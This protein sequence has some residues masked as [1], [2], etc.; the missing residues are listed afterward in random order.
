MSNKR[1]VF[2][3]LMY[4][5]IVDQKITKCSVTSEN[6]RKQMDALQKE[7][8]Y[9]YDLS[10]NNDASDGNYC[11]L[12]FDDGHKSN[13]EAARLLSEI[14]LKGYFY[15]IKDYSINDPEYLNED[16]IR[17][18]AAM[19]H[20]IGVHGK[21]H[22]HW[23][24]KEPGRLVA[25]LRETKDWIEQLT[26]KEVITCSAPGGVID[27]RTIDYIKSEIP[28]LKY[29]RT[30]RYGVNYAGDTVLKS[31]GVL[32]NYSSE[33]VLKIAQCDFLEMGKIMAYY[34]IKESLK[35]LYHKIRK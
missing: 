1:D 18:I 14:G 4:H 32:S 21:D 33:K 12:T 25:E 22:R 30:S 7:G 16:A 26:G 17:E 11:L 34:Y 24:K 6:F 28:E 35:P 27:Q 15:L 9:S 3:S 13:L 5:E 10:G 29:I 19:G 31:I 23:S 8:I 20:E 2:T